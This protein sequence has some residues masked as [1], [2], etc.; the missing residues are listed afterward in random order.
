MS[1]YVLTLQWTRCPDGA[2][3]IPATKKKVGLVR[4][5][6]DRREPYNR[7]LE[8][9]SDLI[10]T[11]FLNAGDM[12]GPNLIRFVDQ[13]GFPYE[14]T[15]GSV[16]LPE[17]LQA[18]AE[19][20]EIWNAYGAG[21]LDEAVTRFRDAAGQVIKWQTATGDPRSYQAKNLSAVSGIQP[22]MRFHDGR[23]VLALPIST[24]YGFM[25]METGLVITGGSQVMR[26]EHCGAIFVTGTGTGRRNT[27]RYCSNR[28]RVAAQRDSK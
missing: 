8:E 17:L 22:D 5:R 21:D 1:N 3:F 10:V 23:P 28:C 14:A 19:L 20:G 16:E 27:S 4:Y 26:C 15:P 7:R 18:R 9:A 11:D 25:L 6:S 2:E 13:H 12:A 24:L